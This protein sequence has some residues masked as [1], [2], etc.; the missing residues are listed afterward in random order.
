M[1]ISK[2]RILQLL[3]DTGRTELAGQA[4]RELP[5]QV[6][7]RRH[8]SLLVKFGIEPQAWLGNLGGGLGSLL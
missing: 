8:A 5:D 2:D 1:N 4:A 6:E 7:T 3:A